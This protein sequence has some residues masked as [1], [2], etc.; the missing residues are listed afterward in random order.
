M[1]VYI[2]SYC[3]YCVYIIFIY[4]FYVCH[5]YY[6]CACDKEDIFGTKVLTLPCFIRSFWLFNNFS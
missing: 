3:A 6:I 1:Y 2:Y 4:T 5:I